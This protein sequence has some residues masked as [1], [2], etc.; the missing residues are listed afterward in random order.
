MVEV[1]AQAKVS[2]LVLMT[3]HELGKFLPLLFGYCYSVFFGLVLI[4]SI[5]KYFF[6]HFLLGGRTHI[7]YRRQIFGCNLEVLLDSAF[8]TYNL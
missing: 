4:F 6:A 8:L 2:Q 1:Q 5:D 7:L 3:N